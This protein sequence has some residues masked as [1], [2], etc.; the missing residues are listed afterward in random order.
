MAKAEAQPPSEQ[1]LVQVP[2]WA[3]VAFAARCASRVQPLFKAAW[4]APHADLVEAVEG[5]IAAAARCASTSGDAA[6][7]H[8]AE[9]RIAAEA[10]RADVDAEY[11]A[12]AAS[13]AARAAEAAR[14]AARATDAADAR[15]ADARAACCAA[16]AAAKAYCAYAGHAA[17][18]GV[19]R[20]TVVTAMRIDFRRLTAAAKKR[21]WTHNTPVSPGFFG[22]LWPKG[23]PARWP[24]VRAKE[25][26]YDRGD[27]SLYFDRAE[28]S[29]EQIAE[30]ISL[31]SELYGSVGGDRLIIRGTTLLIP[32]REPVL[33]GV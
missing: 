16:D 25:T 3:T 6:P 17:G 30:V 28:F 1:E 26:V 20:S 5:A 18:V 10:V 32:E 21:R 8:A 33:E 24:L 29:N 23:E 31:L 14:A 13:Q 22:S 15:A 4:P 2:R 9:A 11:A 19:D 27:M 7:G 12:H